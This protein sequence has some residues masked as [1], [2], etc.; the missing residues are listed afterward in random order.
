MRQRYST[1]VALAIGGVV[2]VR[3][4]IFAMIQASP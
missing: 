1:V 3:A 4:I 2:V